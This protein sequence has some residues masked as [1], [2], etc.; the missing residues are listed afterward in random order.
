MSIKQ[1]PIV[2]KSILNYGLPK[3]SNYYMIAETIKI[4]LRSVQESC[5]NSSA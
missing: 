1:K 2:Q 3:S 5:Y 4:L